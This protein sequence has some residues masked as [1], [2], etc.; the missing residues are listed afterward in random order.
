PPV[1]HREKFP[2]IVDTRVASQEWGYAGGGRPELLVR[3]KSTDI[4]RLT[5]ADVHDVISN[6]GGTEGG[7]QWAEAKRLTA[8]R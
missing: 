8:D 3:I 2:I 5:G 4:I 7:R 6:V 1:G